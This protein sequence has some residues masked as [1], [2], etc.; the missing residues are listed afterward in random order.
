MS[1][2]GQSSGEGARRPVHVL[3][4]DSVRVQ[5]S[6]QEESFEFQEVKSDANFAAYLRALDRAILEPLGLTSDEIDAFSYAAT[7][8]AWRTTS[9]PTDAEFQLLIRDIELVTGAQ[10]DQLLG[11]VRPDYFEPFREARGRGD[12]R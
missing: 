5:R 4:D 7:R 8:N 12:T 10:V 3:R 2:S 6:G 11:A 1:T 9:L